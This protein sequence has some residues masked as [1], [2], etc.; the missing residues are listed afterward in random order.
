MSII[1]WKRGDVLPLFNTMVENFFASDNDFESWWKGGKTM[2]AVN[3]I[4]HEANYLME[5]AAPGM[6]KED[7][8]VEVKEGMIIINAHSKRETETKE[9]NFT[10]REFSYTNFT[11][12][13]R[14]PEN[15]KA[16]N[17]VANYEDGVLSIQLPKKELS[18]PE[19]DVKKIVIS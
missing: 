7:F 5:V 6:K 11:R 1:N 2:P 16:D 17:I 12:S 4:E 13:F 9:E 18:T 8:N 15:V 3:V 19:K 10:R 14:L